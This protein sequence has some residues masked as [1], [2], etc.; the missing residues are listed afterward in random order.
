MTGTVV[1]KMEGAYITP[2]AIIVGTLSL[3]VIPRNMS[4]VL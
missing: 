2:S 4:M 3:A 1:I